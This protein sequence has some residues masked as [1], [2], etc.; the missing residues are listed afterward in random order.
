M[1][2]ESVRKHFFPVALVI[3]LLGH[4]LWTFLIV[5][6]IKSPIPALHISR[7]VFLGSILKSEDISG[8]QSSAFRVEKKFS[9][10]E[11]MSRGNYFNKSF[12]AFYKPKAPVP[13]SSEIKELP[14]SS[15]LELSSPA[16]SS[17]DIVFGISD[18][19]RYLDNVDFAELKRV[20]SREDVSGSILV[21]VL[22]REGGLV[23]DIRVKAGS[24]DP[25]VDL[26]IIRKLRTAVFK[27]FL[28]NSRWVNV[29]IR[30]K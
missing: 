17:A 12:S 5:P 27:E 22:L 26:Y 21:Q 8:Y 19:S 4:L 6:V 30:I 24:G 23:E 10:P 7:S 16:A 28:P 1:I 18:F 15:T 25:L 9:F 2:S 20:S 14:R 29:R 13:L 3:S 11:D